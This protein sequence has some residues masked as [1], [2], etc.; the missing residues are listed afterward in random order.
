MQG[1]NR[2]CF[3]VIRLKGLENEAQLMLLVSIV[4]NYSSLKYGMF[5]CDVIDSQQRRT[6]EKSQFPK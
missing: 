3:D 5:V 6:F 2:V 4:C 1:I